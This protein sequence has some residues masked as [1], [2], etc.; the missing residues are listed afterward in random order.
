VICRALLLLLSIHAVQVQAAAWEAITENELHIGIPADGTRIGFWFPVRAADGRPLY[1]FSCDGGSESYL[2]SLSKDSIN[3]V[4]DMMCLLNEGT[5]KI[6]GS[7]LAE[8]DEAPWH[9]RGQ[10][11]WNELVGDCGLYPEYGRIRHFSL[12]GMRI[13]LRASDIELPHGQL[14]HFT[15]DIWFRNDPAASSSRS[16]PSGY[17]HPGDDCSTV[18]RGVEPPLCRNPTSWSY[19]PCDPPAKHDR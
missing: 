4:A 17:L 8:G 14:S 7:L 18:K 11:R 2:D 3:Y 9:T 10:F 12:R 19:E 1:L 15:L 6:E 16:S 13:T 5:S